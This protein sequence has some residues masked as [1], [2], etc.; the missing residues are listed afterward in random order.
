MYQS[1]LWKQTSHSG[2]ISL[3]WDPQWKDVSHADSLSGGWSSLVF[4]RTGGDGSSLGELNIFFLIRFSPEDVH[5]STPERKSKPASPT[6]TRQR[7]SSDWLGLKAN[8]DGAFLERDGKEVKS[9]V[10]SPEAPSSPLLDRKPSLTGGIHV[11]AAG[12]VA[13]DTAAPSYSSKTQKKEE[14]VNDDWLAGAL[15]RKKALS[16]SEAKTSKQEEYSGRGDNVDLG[17]TVRYGGNHTRKY[18]IQ[19]QKT[20]VCQCWIITC[21]LI[22]A[23]NSLHML[24]KT[25]RTILQLSRKQGKCVVDVLIQIFRETWFY[26][27][28]SRYCGSDPFLGKPIPAAHSIPVRDERPK[29]GTELSQR[30]CKTDACPLHSHS[31][32]LLI[33]QSSC[34]FLYR[35]KTCCYQC[36]FFSAGPQLLHTST[37]VQPQVLKC[38]CNSVS[39]SWFGNNLIQLHESLLYFLKGDIFSRQSTAAAGKKPAY[40][41]SLKYN[42]RLF[43]HLFLTYLIFP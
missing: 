21:L 31:L 36:L 12:K 22:S 25:E 13:A 26:L 4:T 27:L 39:L 11:S 3:P 8:D 9:P 10:D 18:V 20:C 43:T 24:P 41:H 16:S 2:P 15:S 17:S 29:Q 23:T 40:L 19:W 6:S 33:S 32:S 37:A 38:F 7:N 1:H 42:N 5:V 34:N 28:F 35:L 14:E 30:P